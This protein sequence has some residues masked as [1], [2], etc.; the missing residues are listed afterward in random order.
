ML[1][2]NQSVTNFWKTGE[3]GM[4]ECDTQGSGYNQLEGNAISI[5][6]I[7]KKDQHL[8]PLQQ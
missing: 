2:Y 5:V 1:I 3:S 6:L 7:S 4:K 8:A